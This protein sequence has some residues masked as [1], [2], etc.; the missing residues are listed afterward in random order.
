MEYRLVTQVKEDPAL[1]R[2]FFDLAKRVFGLEFAP[3]Y[4][5]GWWSDRYLPYVCLLYTS[6]CV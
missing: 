5:A 3:W 6:R 2:S 4:E 1:C